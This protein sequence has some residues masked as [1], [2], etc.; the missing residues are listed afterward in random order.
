MPADGGRP[1]EVVLVKSGD[2]IPVDGTGARRPRQREPGADHRRVR[3]GGEATRR[4]GVRRDD[5]RA[6]RAPGRDRTGRAGHDVRPDHSARRGG[7]GPK[8]PVQ[9]FADRFTALLHPRGRGGRGWSLISLGRQCHGGG[10]D[11]PGRLLVRDRDG[12]AHAVLA[13]VGASGPARHRRQ[14]GP[15]ARDPGPKVDTVVM[16]KTGT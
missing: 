5:L 16:D 1:G 8:A 4:S 11:R 9:R 15:M 13:S 7:G 2:R 6:R 12:D 14:R 10:G 3:A